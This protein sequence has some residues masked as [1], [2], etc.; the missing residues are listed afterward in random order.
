[1]QLLKSLEG[2]MPTKKLQFTRAEERRCRADLLL[3]SRAGVVPGT[4]FGPSTPPKRLGFRQVEPEFAVVYDLP[5]GGTAFVVPCDYWPLKPRPVICEWAC[6]PNW[7]A[8][9][10]ELSHP[11][12]SPF[13][14]ELLEPLPG[15]PMVLNRWLMGE[16]G[17]P[18]GRKL[19]GV[20]IAINSYPLPEHFDDGMVVSMHLLLS[21]AQGDDYPFDFSARVDRA[22]MLSH[23]RTRDARRAFRPT[24]HL[25]LFEGREPGLGRSEYI[26]PINPLAS[27]GACDLDQ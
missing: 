4:F 22:M 9:D 25:G 13:Y 5:S 14:R 16:V 24:E 20:I 18:H 12:H 1:L 19:S 26:G 3:L 7:D 11:E 21:G 2:A 23:Q 17:L 27:K 10:F 15:T 8:P 6:W